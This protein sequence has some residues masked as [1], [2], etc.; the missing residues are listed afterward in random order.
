M[1]I[2]TGYARTAAG[3]IWLSFEDGAPTTATTDLLDIGTIKYEYDLEIGSDTINATGALLGATTATIS[4]ELSNG[5]S[6]FEAFGASLGGWNLT[7]FRVGY[8]PTMNAT[9]YV[10]RNATTTYTFPYEISYFDLA[11]DERSR[12]LS[13][14]LRPR[15]MMSNTNVGQYWQAKSPAETNVFYY[16]DSVGSEQ[17]IN[18][19]GAGEFVLDQVAEFGGTSTIWAPA[20]LNTSIAA[21]NQLA[22][23]PYSNRS[24]LEDRKVV[25]CVANVGALD[26]TYFDR[27]VEQL[28]RGLAAWEGA[29]FGSAFSVNFYINR[30]R[31]DYNVELTNSQLIDIKR[32]R[33]RNPVRQIATT[34]YVEKDAA[35]N[36]PTVQNATATA[37]YQPWASKTYSINIANLSPHIQSAEFS[38]SPIGG[39]D[40]YAFLAIGG[41]SNAFNS[42]IELAVGGLSVNALAVASGAQGAFTNQ[43]RVEFT[44]FGIDSVK[45]WQA[46][47]FDEDTTRFLAYDRTAAAITEQSTNRHYR[48]TSIE[49]N[50]KQDTV[51]VSAYEIDARYWSF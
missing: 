48:P 42:N 10:Q 45:P 18:A 49:Y 50:L 39:R 25:I 19:V 41:S 37:N 38:Y 46:V 35:E 7:G 6:A 20:E 28:V 32:A 33:V 9:L 4:D 26:A 40:P 3:T 22:T 43:Q 30:Q 5:I 11:E 24:Q 1:A 31:K 16:I 51:T 15:R 8:P 27:P 13:M 36:I 12:A 2:N 17:E 29:I 21:Y 47:R 14:T 44:A 34:L 23:Y